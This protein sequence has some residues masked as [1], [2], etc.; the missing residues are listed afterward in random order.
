MMTLGVNLLGIIIIVLIIWWFWFSTTK[1]KV[2]DES[3]LIEI[4]VEDGVYTPA[5]IE[6]AANQKF[7]LRFLRKDPGPCAEKVV[8]DQLD[9]SLVLPVNETVELELNLEEAGEYSF[10]CDMQMYRGSL[11]VKDSV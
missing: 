4:L 11:I 8:F 3:R 2:I 6:V 9:K 5:R 7:T 10:T 1:A